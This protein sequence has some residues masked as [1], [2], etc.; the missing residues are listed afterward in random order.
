MNVI[1]HIGAHR[2]AT[3]SFQHYLRHNARRLS[4]AR[5]GFWGP[6]RTR[7]GLFS[8]VLPGPVAVG[9]GDPA[10]RAAGRISL[11][12]ASCQLGGHDALIVS[13][14]NVLGSVRENLRLGTLYAGAGER[15][16]RYLQAFG[17]NISDIVINIRSQDHYWASALGYATLRGINPPPA[18]RL[19][20]IAEQRRAWRDVI[21]DI[22]RSAGQA[23]VLVFPFESFCGQPETQLALMTGIAPPLAEA[24]AW[25]NRSPD[26]GLMAAQFDGAQWPQQ[27]RSGRWM[28]FAPTQAEALRE[29][30]ADDIHWLTSGADGLATLMT[31]HLTT[32]PGQTGPGHDKTRGRTD[33]RQDRR[34]A[35]AR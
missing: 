19:R 30:Y 35:Q 9:G 34:L 24:R 14:E 6:R 31:N 28:P 10:R 16:A 1:F 29:T 25:L 26:A 17:G 32:R 33:D 8:G 20:V 3:T 7:N 27:A 22:A 12:M 2:C 23:R 11:A 13:D 4:E 18:A 21:T 15:V 5:I